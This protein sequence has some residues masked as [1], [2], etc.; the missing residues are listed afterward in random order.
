MSTE[1]LRPNSDVSV[2]HSRSTGSYNYACVDEAV[3][4][5]TDYVR[6]SRNGI[7]ITR[8]DVYGSGDA[9]SITASD[10]ITAVRVCARARKALAYGTAQLLLGLIENGV[11]TIAEFH[12]TTESYDTYYDEW[13]VRPSDGQ[14]W[15][16]ADIQSLQGVLRS[17]VGAPAAYTQVV[18]IS[19]YWIEVD[20]APA[21]SG[22]AQVIAPQ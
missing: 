14:P 8:T 22:W 11:T 19:Q 6:S 4:D 9:A 18:T 2:Q 10:S 3:A 17:I 12:S 7:N 16:L 5:D 21:P 13:A 1:A 20:Y 15:T